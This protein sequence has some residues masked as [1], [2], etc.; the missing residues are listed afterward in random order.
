M[1]RPRRGILILGLLLVAVNRV[2]GLVLPVST[3]YLMDNVI[4]KR[5]AQPADAADRL[6]WAPR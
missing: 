4:G 3:K 6:C 1:I 5:E 2:A